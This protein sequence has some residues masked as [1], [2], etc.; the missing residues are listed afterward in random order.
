MS[1]HID[2][3]PYRSI[4]KA[5]ERGNARAELIGPVATGGTVKT[6]VRGP[7]PSP[8]AGGCN[9]PANPADDTTPAGAIAAGQSRLVCRVAAR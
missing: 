8:R 3:R 1:H 4:G 7:V 5:A 9:P 2:S 6:T